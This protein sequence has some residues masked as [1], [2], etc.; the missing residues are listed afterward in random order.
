MKA[1][2]PQSAFDAKHASWYSMQ[3]KNGKLTGT[4]V[5][6]PPRAKAAAAPT[7]TAAGSTN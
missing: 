5:A 2:F 7:G 6:I 4:K 3:L 1:E